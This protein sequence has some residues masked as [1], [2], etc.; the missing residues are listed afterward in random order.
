MANMCLDQILRFIFSGM[1]ERLPQLDAV[2]QVQIHPQAHLPQR[3]ILERGGHL[4]RGQRSR[5][6]HPSAWLRKTPTTT[7]LAHT[8]YFRYY[9]YPGSKWPKSHMKML[10][11]PEIL[12]LLK[13]LLSTKLRQFQT[14]GIWFP[15]DISDIT[16]I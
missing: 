11:I 4:V 6:S 3:P 10:I 5:R 12:L 2:G 8:R 9:R 13:L 14:L 15:L 1:Y 7:S 16:D